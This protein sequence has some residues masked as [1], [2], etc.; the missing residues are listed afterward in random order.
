MK[1]DFLEAQ[2]FFAQQEIPSELD[3]TLQM[4]PKLLAS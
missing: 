1:L 4:A 2:S 3:F